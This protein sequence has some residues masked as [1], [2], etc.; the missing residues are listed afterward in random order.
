MSAGIDPEHTVIPVQSG[1]ASEDLALKL[2]VAILDGQLAPG[3]RLPSE[4]EMQVRF[5]T[6]RGVV[7]EALKILKQKGLLDVRKGVKG[8][9]Y[10]RQLEVANV[11]ES[12]AL[13]LKQ[14][15]VAPEKL[16]EFRESM[17][18]TITLLAI[19]RA[20][21]SEKDHLLQE[22]LRLG[23]LLRAPDSDLAVIGEL[24]RGLNLMLARMAR[25]PLFEWVMDALQ[26]G[27][28][29]HDY[30]LYQDPVYR[31]KAAANWSDTARAIADSEPMRA[32]SC[33][34]RHYSMLRECV[35]ERYEEDPGQPDPKTEDAGDS[36]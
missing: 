30:T 15:P 2:E 16:V 18:R 33:I 1:R 7:R 20:T 36:P 31:D 14:H 26:M 29:S 32:L 5:G 23:S 27:F 3:E 13:F 19:A 11:S 9:A 17:D 34:G 21:L 6:S 8:G 4:R 35:A 25:N 10:V 28:I 12:L 24:D 22:A